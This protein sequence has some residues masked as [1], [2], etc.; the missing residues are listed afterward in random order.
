MCVL[1]R[2]HQGFLLYHLERLSCIITWTHTSFLPKLRCMCKYTK[3][4]LKACVSLCLP[5]TMFPTTAQ[6]CFSNKF[7]VHWSPPTPCQCLLNGSNSACWILQLF[8]ALRAILGWEGKVR[9]F[10]IVIWVGIFN[11]CP[12]GVGGREGDKHNLLKL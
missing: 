8:L 6:V 9:Q 12:S 10:I 5:E 7:L 1:G 2:K 3:S 4:L 11:L